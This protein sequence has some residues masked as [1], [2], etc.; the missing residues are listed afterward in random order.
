M[1]FPETIT[2]NLS[3]PRDYSF[4]P[5]LIKNGIVKNGIIYGINGSGKTSLGRAVFDI[6]TLANYKESYRNV[7]Y[8]GNPHSTIDFSYSF[9]F[10]DCGEVDYSYSKTIE[11]TIVKELLTYNGKEVLSRDGG[12]IDFSDEF[13]IDRGRK[14]QLASSP[15]SVSL[16]KFLYASIPLEENHPIV[17]LIHFSESMLWFRCLD[18]TNFI[19][20]D[21][22]VVF[23]HEY[24]IKKGYLKEYEDFLFKESGQKFDLSPTPSEGKIIFC[25]INGEVVPLDAIKSTGTRSLE[26]LFYWIKRMKENSV[27]FVFI[28]EFD[29]FYHFELSI[30]VC[31]LLFAE[32]FQVFL[33]SHNTLLLQNDFL[34]P[35]CAF[36]LRQN[37]INPLSEL[38]DRGE[39]REGH[40]IEKMFRAGAFDK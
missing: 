1:G 39:L 37:R 13:P 27:K 18:Q 29:A 28:D 30:K 14:E 19:G 16:V 6:V 40:N 2:W 31:Q 33:S 34:R 24:I 26:L 38:T 35:D 20:I 10:D 36:Y 17:R 15:N 7:I 9:Q 22:G 5:H 12:K 32:D 25:K 23:L 3:N 4:N 21:D 8:A 11:G